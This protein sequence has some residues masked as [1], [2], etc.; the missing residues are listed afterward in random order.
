MCVYVMKKNWMVSNLFGLSFCTEGIAEMNIGS[1][2]VGAALL[3]LLYIYREDYFFMIFFGYLEQMLW[4][5]LQN[6]L[7]FQLN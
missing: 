3:V 4:L 7:I 2:Y 1:Y 5:L 6:H